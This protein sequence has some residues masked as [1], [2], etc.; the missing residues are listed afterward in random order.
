M[1]FL[2][3][4]FILISFSLRAKTVS[5][6]DCSKQA[7]AAAKALT[8]ASYP[9]APKSSFEV[10][11]SAVLGPDLYEVSVT[12]VISPFQNPTQLRYKIS[13]WSYNDKNKCII[14]KAELF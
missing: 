14:D 2:F 9:S 5:N 1:K 10:S 3:F 8:E 4:T 13:T 12:N 6:E 11:E 7:E